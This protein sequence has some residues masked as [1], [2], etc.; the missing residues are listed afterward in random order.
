MLEALPLSSVSSSTCS[1]HVSISVRRWRDR[2]CWY[3]WKHSSSRGCQI[4]S[5]VTDQHSALK[6]C[7]Q[8]Q[9]PQSRPET[10][11]L[12]VSFKL[13]LDSDTFPVAKHS[14]INIKC[15]LLSNEKKT[16]HW[17]QRAHMKENALYLGV[18][19]QRI[20]GMLPLHLAALYGFPDCCRKLL[21]NGKS[22]L[23]SPLSKHD[24]KNG[25]DLFVAL[26]GPENPCVSIRQW[27][28][29]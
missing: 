19:R 18:R 1:C 14:L 8:E 27:R 6:W 23:A 26:I 16:E 22:S 29:Y 13:H 9:V 11:S 20:D 3:L 12:I 25:T 21:S 10:D 7:Q 24:L 15:K 28:E 17:T 4:W 2:L 5:G